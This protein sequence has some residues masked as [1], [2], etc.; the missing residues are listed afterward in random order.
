MIFVTVGSRQYPFDRLFKKIDELISQNKI[1]QDV[2][3]QIGTANYLPQNYTYKRY[4]DPKEMNDYIKHAKIIISHGGSASV[5]SALAFQKPTILAPRLSQYHEHINDHQVRFVQ[6]FVDDGYAL[7]AGLELEYLGD[8]IR[9]CE[10]E[11]ISFKP[12]RSPNDLD[13]VEYLFEY[14]QKDSKEK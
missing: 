11:E 13:I 4:L 7:F 5:L 3:A 1:H 8:C 9:Q 2:Y 14:I 6:Q 12:W 10:N